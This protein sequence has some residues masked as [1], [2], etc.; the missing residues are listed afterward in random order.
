MKKKKK[1]AKICR[2]KQ[3]LHNLPHSKKL[4]N[5]YSN[6]PIYFYFYFYL[7]YSIN[8]NHMSELKR[9][10]F[11]LLINKLFIVVEAAIIISKLDK[12]VKLC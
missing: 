6:L 1:K 8:T 2:L 9:Q 3:F 10:T 7:M 12:V 11:F 5:E 4:A